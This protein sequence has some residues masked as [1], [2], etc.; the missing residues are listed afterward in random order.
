MTNIRVLCDYD[1]DN[2]PPFGDHVHVVDDEDV[3]GLD[4]DTFDEL[5]FTLKLNH[6]AAV[7]LSTV[8]GIGLLTIA[9]ASAK[10]VTKLLS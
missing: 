1:D 7:V 10:I 9:R 8:V 5:P 6:R 3:E 4:S 2:L